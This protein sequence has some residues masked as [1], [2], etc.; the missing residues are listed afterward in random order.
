M[1]RP[2][3]AGVLTI[4]GGLFILVG[5]AVFA[6]VGG[7]LFALFHVFSGLF[8]V[9]LVA[10]LLTILMGVLM[11]AVPSGHGVWGIAT[12]IFA[13]L[14]VPFA[15]AGFILGF[16]LALAGGVVAVTWRPPR[17]GTVVTV[18]GRVVG[19]PPG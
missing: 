10:G 7:F 3:A 14:S 2:L 18:A 1:P 19:P 5:G 9:G 17:I 4:L 6:V 11:L 12:I 15:L 13:L 8:L 16:V